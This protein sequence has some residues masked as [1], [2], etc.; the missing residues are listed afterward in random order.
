MS[1]KNNQSKKKLKTN[2]TK[3]VLLLKLN[4]K[5]YLWCIF[6]ILSLFLL[7]TLYNFYLIL[8]LRTDLKGCNFYS[9]E[10]KEDNSTLVNKSNTN[11]DDTFKEEVDSSVQLNTDSDDLDLHITKKYKISSFGDNFSSGVYLNMTE[12]NMYLD[13]IITSLTFQPLYE[14]KKIKDCEDKDISSCLPISEIESPSISKACLE[15]GCLEILNNGVYF[16]NKKLSLP[17][18]LKDEN[19]LRMSVGK[20]DNVWLLGVVI[21]ESYDEAGL[22]FKFDGNNFSTLISRDTDNKILPKYNRLGGYIGFGGEDDNFL[23]VYAGYKGIA[24]QIKS[25]SFY[26]ISHF[27]GFRVT[28]PSFIP[29]V[30]KTREDNESVWYISSLTANKPKLIKLWQNGTSNIKGALDLSSLIFKDNNLREGVSYIFLPFNKEKSLY[31]VSNESLFVFNDL[32]FDNSNN[33]QIVSVNI[34]DDGYRNVTSA[35]IKDLKISNRQENLS[36]IYSF[37][38]N[39]NIELYLSNQKGRW[40]KVNYKQNYYFLNNNGEQLF[41]KINFKRILDRQ[42]YS[43]WVDS[44]NELNYSYLY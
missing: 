33:Y 37:S 26:D 9:N 15:N 7:F 2:K 6:L 29:Q 20:L 16:N 21:G 27:F 3:N 40:E 11:N 18:E 30:L 35:V 25:D 10:I 4:F 13:D 12:T 22:V 43:P 8:D 31:I 17:K 1:I 44:L 14:F 34:Q 32:G 23:I 41:W 38:Q 36:Y 42:Y 5:I 19:V 28:D 39:D 24:Y